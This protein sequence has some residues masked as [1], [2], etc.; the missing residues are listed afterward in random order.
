MEE[1]KP[2]RAD[3]IG[4]GPGARL[5][6][7][8][9]AI[10][11]VAAI[12]VAP[13]RASSGYELDPSN[14]VLDLDGVPRGLAVDQ[15]SRDLYVAILSMDL[16]NLVPG[17]IERFKSDLSAD[18]T[19]AEGGGYY[20]GVGVNPLTHGFY[21]ARAEFRTPFGNF[22]VPGLDRFSS[23]GALAGSTA[24]MYANALPTI[25]TDSAGDVFYPN[26]EADSVQVFSPAGV[27][28]EEITC[29]GCSGGLF[30]APISVALNSAD[31]LYVVDAEP[32]R[33][34]KLTPSG[35][36]YSFASVVQ[37]DRGAGAVGVDPGTGDVLVGDM[38]NGR[39][40]HIIA[41]DSSGTQF[42]DFGSGLFL[43][44]SPEA[45]VYAA[46]QMA[47]DATS[48][49]LYVS[50]FE[51]IYVFDQATID[52]PTAT[53]E[54]GTD[55]GQ[56]TATLNATVNASGHAVLECEFEYTEEADVSF[57]NATAVPC[58]E[59]PVGSGDTELSVEVGLSPATAYRYR[60]TATNN[61]GSTTSG[62][63]TFE[64]LP[65]VPATV[66]MESPL[67]VTQNAATIVGKV[68][69]RGGSVSNCHFEF[70]TSTAYGTVLPCLSLLGP[71]SSDVVESRNVSELVNSTTYHYRLVVTTNAGTTKGNDIAFTT[72][73]PPS[74]PK[75][76]PTTTPEATATPGTTTPQPPSNPPATPSRPRGCKK[77]FH[78]RRV[79]GKARCVKKKS[80]GRH[81]AHRS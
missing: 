74:E 60:V 28:E 12:F 46:G 73:S 42:D 1:I 72:A 55:I 37:S 35:G 56:L 5:A 44:A 4:A 9:L 79:H 64:T 61:A 75:P 40:A 25:A 3:A 66:T 65:A 77:G 32:D 38:P 7:L 78:K 76:P 14:P 48:H 57:T 23:A 62:S 24:L 15:E 70:G 53:V 21:G 22:G 11:S 30:G 51:K 20:T 54:A 45:G 52:P 67:A 17:Q 43:D 80:A 6:V 33:V 36:S 47:V 18:G 68:N 19:F 2:R 63:Q 59:L 8:L 50:A 26:R 41:Y 31:D 81:G 58:S 29:E 69:P 71:V 49:K 13:A 10:A 16:N 27:L 39:G 34:V